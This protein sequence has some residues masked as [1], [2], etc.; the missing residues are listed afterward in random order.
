MSALL[1]VNGLG[2]SFGGVHAVNG[3]DFELASGEIF[4]LIG[5]N[6]A[7]KT[8]LFNLI[9]GVIRPDTGRVEFDGQDITGMVPY[10]V[11]HHG[12][13]RTHQ[14]VKPLNDMTVLDNVIVGACFGPEQASLSDATAAAREALDTVELSDRSDVLAGKLNLASKKRLEIARALAGRP[15]LLLL[16][17]TLSGLNPTEVERMIE[18]VRRIR[19]ELSV[20]ILMIEHLMQV[21]M[22]LSDRIM[23]LN[24]GQQLATGTPEEI[25]NNEQVVEAYLGDP[26]LAERLMEDA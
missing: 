22:A 14:I 18:I 12:L 6:G 10:R 25:V 19:S 5:P 8:T 4:G 20:S 16:D 2:K 17:E 9:N 1:S 26:G 24:F 11:V 13:A 7:G 23:V 21:I 3:V 15:R